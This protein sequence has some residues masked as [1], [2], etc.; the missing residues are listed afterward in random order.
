MTIE[1]S[2]DSRRARNSASLTIG[3]RRRPAS[4]PSRRRCFLAS[5]RVEPLTEV[6]SSSAERPSR[7]LTTVLSGSSGEPLGC[8]PERARRRRRR[9]PEP[10]P[11]LLPPFPFPLPFPL[12]DP[13]P[14]PFL[15]L[16]LL[17]L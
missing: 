10:S 4:R 2:T 17:P 16:P 7:T 9:V 8:S 11:S 6:I 1:R 12:P 13:L 14:L 3:A 5:R 15:A